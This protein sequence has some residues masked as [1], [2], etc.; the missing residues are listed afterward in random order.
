M[1]TRLKTPRLLPC[2]PDTMMNRRALESGVGLLQ[3]LI[4]KG[5]NVGVR[6]AITSFIDSNQASYSSIRALHQAPAAPAAREIYLVPL[7]RLLPEVLSLLRKTPS[8]SH[9]QQP[10]AD[11]QHGF[12]R[13]LDLYGFP[14]LPRHRTSQLCL[15]EC[16]RRITKC[17][18]PNWR[19][20][21]IRVEVSRRHK[22]DCPD[23]VRPP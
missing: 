14:A 10:K 7:L 6:A 2:H 3:R 21:A 1:Y 8:C 11:I 13:Q 22:Q 18:L 9:L 17:H 19:L 5:A 12:P 15:L 16:H 4:Q 23:N 20:L